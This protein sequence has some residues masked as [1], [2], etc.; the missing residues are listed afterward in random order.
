MRYAVRD[1]RSGAVGSF[2][3]FVNVPDVTGGAFALSGLIVRSGEVADSR[4]SIDSDRFSLR[5]VDALRV[6]AMGTRLSY[7]YEVYNAGTAV[8]VATTVWR[9]SEKVMALPPETLI[10]SAHGATV[11]ATGALTLAEHL[12]AGAYVLQIVATSDDP[13]SPKKT[14]AA[15]QRLSFEVK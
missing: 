12:S 15:V 8:Q 6:Y 4:E 2:G 3:G 5:P 11:A 13:N 14:R 9:A 7:A 1:R 10:P